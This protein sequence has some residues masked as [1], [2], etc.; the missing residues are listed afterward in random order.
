[1]IA[2][3]NKFAFLV[4]AGFKLET[5]DQRKV[6][7]VSRDY[8]CQISFRPVGLSSDN[9]AQLNAELYRAKLLADFPGIRIIKSF[10]SI[11]DSHRGP[12]WEVQ[13]PGPAGTSRR[14]IVAYIPSRALVLEFQMNCTPEKFDSARQQLSTVM[15]TFRASDEQ[16]Q[17]HISP[18]SDK[19]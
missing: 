17:L 19:L 5:W 10:E 7:A 3:T 14:G 13:L 9:G 12:A 15:L 6:A 1:V 4:P 8:S 18:L 11:A 2:G 16:G